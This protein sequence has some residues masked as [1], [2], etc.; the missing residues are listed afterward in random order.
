MS[1]LISAED[2][3]VG[4]VFHTISPTMESW[5]H[6]KRVAEPWQG[7][8]ASLHGDLVF[9]CCSD[10]ETGAIDDDTNASTMCSLRRLYRDHLEA[11]EA[12]VAD[13]RHE[14]E[15]RL[16]LL[17]APEEILERLREREKGGGTN[18]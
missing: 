4:D 18:G 17:K 15:Q 2:V 1:S 9:L 3:K 7:K 6:G 16:G 13:L 14:V 11:Y 12:Y 10:P 8:V 5:T